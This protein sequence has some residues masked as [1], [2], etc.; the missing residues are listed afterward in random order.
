MVAV[1][2]GVDVRDANVH[3]QSDS[4]SPKNPLFTLLDLFA[5][6]TPAAAVDGSGER[7]QKRRKVDNGGSVGLYSAEAF[8]EDKSVV[9]TNVSLDLVRNHCVHST[10]VVPQY[11]HAHSTFR[12][13]PAATSSSYTRQMIHKVLSSYR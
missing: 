11:L 7:A 2:A 10:Q 3:G 12:P 4:A 1:S 8:D 13:P 6:K 9:L 5:T